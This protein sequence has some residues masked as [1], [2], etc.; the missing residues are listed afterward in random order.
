[1]SNVLTNNPLTIDTAATITF[2]RPLLAKDI[3]W[4][5]AATVGNQAI[6]TDLGGN[7]RAQAKC[8]VVNQT[9]ELWA[10]GQGRLTLKS[11]FV[12]S[13]INSG[14]LMIWY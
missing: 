4:V 8:A 11:P 6:I 13:T 14:T 9:V 10:G 7:I 1:M 5:G 3:Q 12:V 2:S